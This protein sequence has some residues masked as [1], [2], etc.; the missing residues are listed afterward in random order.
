M[1]RILIMLAVVML[2]GGIATFASS[3]LQGQLCN[4]RM[5]DEPINCQAHEACTQSGTGCSGNPTWK[6][7][8]GCQDRLRDRCTGC[9][10]CENLCYQQ[11][12]AV[13]CLDADGCVDPN[14]PCVCDDVD[15]SATCGANP[16]AITTIL[17]GPC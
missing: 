15:E 8:H 9:G 4:H 17:Y 11:T 14:D 7:C 6:A 1:N 2:I 10:T 16:Q 13:Y 3:P 5:P 12:S